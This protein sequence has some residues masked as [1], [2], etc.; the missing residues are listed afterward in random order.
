MAIE[1]ATK[2]YL[3]EYGRFPLQS[4]SADHAYQ[5]DQSAYIGALCAVATSTNHNPRRIAFLELPEAYKGK[6]GEAIDYW[7]HQLQIV[8]DWSMDG[9]VNVGS[10]HLSRSLALWSFGSD[11]RNDYGL[12][13]D[14]TSWQ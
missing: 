6:H 3:A 4:G 11:G 5:D 12:G 1:S 13:D 2:A 14:V 10:N 9:H 7:G 8:A